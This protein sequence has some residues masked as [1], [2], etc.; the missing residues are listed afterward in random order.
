MGWGVS[1]MHHKKFY[2]LSGTYHA[3]RYPQGGVLNMGYSL[4]NSPIWGVTHYS[5]MSALDP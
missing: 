3:L 5:V 2:E 1:K 4:Y